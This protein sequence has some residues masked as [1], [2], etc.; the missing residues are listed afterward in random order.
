MTH[1]HITA[2]LLALILFFVALGLQKGGNAKGAKIVQMILRVLYILILLTGIMMLFDLTTISMLY[3][4]KSAVGL[5][6]IALFEIILAR[7]SRNENAS[8]LWIQFAIAL[9]LVLYLGFS[10]PLGFDWF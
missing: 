6:I 8:V 1:A 2:W 4:L 10:L 5:W 7:T 9:V 3:I